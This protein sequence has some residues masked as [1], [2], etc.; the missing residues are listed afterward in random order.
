LG[1][2]TKPDAREF[3][4][5]SEPAAEKMKHQGSEAGGSRGYYAPLRSVM[6]LD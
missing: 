3:A 6:V 2:M 5:S 4:S 1:N